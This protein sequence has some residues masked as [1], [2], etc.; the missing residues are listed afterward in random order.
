[1]GTH[2]RYAN[3]GLESFEVTYR[4]CQNDCYYG[5]LQKNIQGQKEKQKIG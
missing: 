1:M 2:A 3:E 5:Y 4:W